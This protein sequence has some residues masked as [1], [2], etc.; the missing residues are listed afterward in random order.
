MRD[1]KKEFKL[2]Q[3]I[4]ENGELVGNVP[5]ELS[6]DDLIEMMR[7]MVYMRVVDERSISLNRQGRLG[8]YAP[9]SG[10]EASGIGSQYVLDKEKD[11]IVPGYRDLPQLVYHGFPLYKMYLYSRG[12]YEG[13]KVPKGINVLLQ[14]VIIAAQITQ[15]TGVALA[16]KIKKQP[17]VVVTYTGDGATSQG[18]FYEGLNFAGVYNA[19]VIFVVQNNQFAISTPMENQTKAETIAQKAIA[20]GIE[21]VRVDGMDVL[22]VYQAT[23]EAKE[24]ALNGQGPTLLELVNFRFGPHTMAGDDPKRYREEV[25]EKE[26][27]AK[28]PLIRFR[29]ALVRNG[30]WDKKIE[31]E[32][33][34]NAKKDIGEAIKMADA[35]PKQKVTDLLGFMYEEMPQNLK[36]QYLQYLAEERK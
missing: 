11:W 7:R 34:E 23:K 14:Q 30:L 16:M 29:K 17:S 25:L 9:F 13:G 12:H 28:D 35:A 20:A 10:Q 24:R 4:D 6:D 1:Y 33:I 18:D 22:A 2:Q 3:I 21:S 36:E 8:L 15:A 26:W 32:T 5:T 27:L 19:P 31:N